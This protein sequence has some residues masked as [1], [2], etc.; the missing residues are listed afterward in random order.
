MKKSNCYL[1]IFLNDS[2]GSK[3]TNDVHILCLAYRHVVVIEWYYAFL[4]DGISV[5]IGQT[6]QGSISFHRHLELPGKYNFM[7]WTVFLSISATC[8]WK[9]LEWREQSATSEIFITT[10]EITKGSLSTELLLSRKICPKEMLFE[11]P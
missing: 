5:S 3:Q 2:H 11:G 1:S 6:W 7:N 8:Y 9:T 10:P 4:Q